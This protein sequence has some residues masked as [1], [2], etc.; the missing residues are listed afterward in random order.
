[1]L[2]FP[3]VRWMFDGEIAQVVTVRDGRIVRL[4]G[5]EEP[6]DALAAVGVS[7]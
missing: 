7:E 3:A 6:D 4:D 2:T 5:Y 1:M